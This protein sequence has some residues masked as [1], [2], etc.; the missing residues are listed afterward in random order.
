[1]TTHPGAK[2]YF[3]VSSWEQLQTTKT[4]PCKGELNA[5]CHAIAPFVRKKIHAGL[6]TMVIVPGGGAVVTGTGD[7]AAA[8]RVNVR[9][10]KE[11]I[12]TAIGPTMTFRE[13]HDQLV[14]KDSKGQAF[15]KNKLKRKSAWGIG[16]ITLACLCFFV[17]ATGKSA[18]IPLYVWLP[19]AMAGPTPV[20]ALI[21]AA[22]MVTAGVYMIA[23]MNFLFSLSATACG[24]IALV[25][26]LTALFAATMGFFQYDLKKVLAYSTVSQ[27]GFMFIAV[28]VGSYWAGVFHLMTHAFFKACLFLAAGSVIHGMHHIIHDEVGSQDMRN[29]G[30]LKRVMPKT[31]KT[32]AIACM[33]ITA[34]PPGLAGFWSKDELLWKAWNTQ[35]T[36][37]VSGKLIYTMGLLAALGT[38]F[39]MW[40]SYYLTFTGKHQ[41][42]DIKDHVHES[43]G[44]MTGVLWVLAGLAA[45]SGIIL[46]ISQHVVPLSFLP[47]EP[48]LEQWLHPVTAHSAAV[49]PSGDHTMMYIL[50]AVS[51]F[52]ALGMWALAKRLYGPGREGWE[53]WEKSLPGF[54]VMQNKYY[55]DEIYASSIVAAFM[56]LRLVL[57]EIDRWIVDGIV[58][59]AGVVGRGMARVAS[60]IDKY[61]VDGAVNGVANATMQAGDKLRQAQTGRVQNY[62][63]GILGGVAFF[64]IVTYLL[65]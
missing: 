47:H 7:E 26:A 22:T 57:A 28:G 2:V 45:F 55:V 40:R 37:F 58:N 17:G 65:G 23:R 4:K 16:L 39:Y 62:I 25:G 64:A 14:I 63:Y 44:A 43:P 54:D 9:P 13:L 11:M 15:V 49:I 52:G 27:L 6:H 33:A 35:A 8:L 20:S 32:F 38:S 56:R 48:L 50:M 60:L 18:Q 30:G 12:L 41:R 10:G 59:G 42:D 34:V 1:M 51:V 46:G 29:M 24:V 31:A 21:H 3:G 53:G 61:G 36:G 19:D 5:N